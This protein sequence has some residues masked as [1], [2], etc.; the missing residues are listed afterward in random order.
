MG[1]LMT[2]SKEMLC[3]RG[4]VGSFVHRDVMV[5]VVMVVVVIVCCLDHS[6]TDAFPITWN[7]H[8]HNRVVSLTLPSPS[9][10]A[11]SLKVSKLSG[12]MP[13]RGAD[14][15]NEK[16]ALLAT[17]NVGTF[18]ENNNDIDVK[19]KSLSDYIINK[20]APLFL[21]GNIQL[22]TPV[23]VIKTSENGNKDDNIEE[24]AGCSLI[25]QK[26]DT[27]YKSK[28]EEAKGSYQRQTSKE[29]EAKGSY[30]RQTDNIEDRKTIK[31]SSPS[32]QEEKKQGGVQIFVEK[33]SGSLQVRAVRCEIDDDTVIKEMSEEVIIRE[34]QKAINVWKKEI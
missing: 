24:I 30:Q 6:L 12:W 14:Q 22:T 23:Q 8:H 26:I 20:W 32:K 7:C 11:I 33:L 16:D 9:T 3:S 25:F 19:F 2:K 15:K 1:W 29:E 27:G 5:V 28:D 21:T 17:Y 34:L 4:D 13:G 18:K 31:S 10:T